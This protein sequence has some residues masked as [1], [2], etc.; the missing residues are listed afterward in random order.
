MH[1][2]GCIDHGLVMVPSTI[3]LYFAQ[4]AV[5][6]YQIQAHFQ[7]PRIKQAEQVKQSGTSNC[8]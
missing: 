2:C 4:D 8:D 7:T 3:H 6:A 1:A 5:W